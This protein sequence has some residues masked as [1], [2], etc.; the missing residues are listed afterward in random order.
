MYILMQLVGDALCSLS[1]LDAS[2]E[3]SVSTITSERFLCCVGQTK[4]SYTWIW[5]WC[6]HLVHHGSNETSS[7]GQSKFLVTSSFRN[8]TTDWMWSSP[9]SFPAAASKGIASKMNRAANPGSWRGLWSQQWNQSLIVRFPVCMIMLT[10]LLFLV[11]I[12]ALV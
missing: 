5:A 10:W 4:E 9:T 11:W 3:I 1:A 12:L 6:L 7:W 8:S 2:W